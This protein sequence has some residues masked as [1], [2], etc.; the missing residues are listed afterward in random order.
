MQSVAVC[1]EQVPIK[2][3]AVLGVMSLGVESSA[4]VCLNSGSTRRRLPPWAVELT[5]GLDRVGLFFHQYSSIAV[6][7]DFLG[8]S[9][10]EGTVG[11]V[12]VV[13]EEVN[14]KNWKSAHLQSAKS[15]PRSFVK[16]VTHLHGWPGVD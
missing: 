16:Y 10:R 6:K 1:L 11:G 13:V 3:A 12:R 5:R 2:V 4:I 9:V 8:D 7:G 14:K 15:L